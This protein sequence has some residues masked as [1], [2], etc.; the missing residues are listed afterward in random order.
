MFLFWACFFLSETRTEVCLFHLHLLPGAWGRLSRKDRTPHLRAKS[1]AK[2]PGTLERGR[3]AK[4]RDGT[5]VLRGGPRRCGTGQLRPDASAGGDRTW[6]AGQ[7][8]D[9]GSCAAAP[10]TSWAWEAGAGAGGG[11]VGGQPAYMLFGEQGGMSSPRQRTPW[12][13][14][15]ARLT[16]SAARGK[17]ATPRAMSPRREHALRKA[18]R[19]SHAAT[20]RHRWARGTGTGETGLGC[21]PLTPCPCCSAEGPGARPTGRRPGKGRH[22][23]PRARRPEQS[24]GGSGQRGTSLDWSLQFRKWG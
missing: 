21:L 24:K 16:D 19:G 5:V 6:G 14:L 23:R 3:S 1:R 9:S 15:G 4:R 22:L 8:A 13:G 2:A 20:R 10:G 17:G 12:K 18:R 7:V 11:G